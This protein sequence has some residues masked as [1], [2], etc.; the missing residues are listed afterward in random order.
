MRISLRAINNGVSANGFCNYSLD[1]DGR[2]REWV[3]RVS[4]D[5]EMGKDINV[6]L[7]LNYKVY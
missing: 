6:M 1:A 3:G 2:G 7:H 4:S 5:G